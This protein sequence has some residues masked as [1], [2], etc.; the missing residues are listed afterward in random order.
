MRRTLRIVGALAVL[1]IVQGALVAARFPAPSPAPDLARARALAAAA[2][3]ELAGVTPRLNPHPRALTGKLI[4]ISLERQELVAWEDGVAV[5][6]FVVSTGMPGSETPT[7]F[8][9][10]FEKWDRR[11][12]W[13]WKVWMPYAMRF[14]PG[15]GFFIHELTYWPGH[16]EERNGVE[17]LGRPASHGCVRVGLGDA[18]TLYDWTDMGTPVW[19]H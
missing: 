8:W 17:D 19:V 11:F 18:K 5:H 7:G 4:E 1:A 10:V 14:V 15:R 13:T 6:R 12:S 3:D 9:A 2:G 16:P